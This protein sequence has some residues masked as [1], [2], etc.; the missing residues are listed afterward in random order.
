NYKI[1]SYLVKKKSFLAKKGGKLYG[2]TLHNAIYHKHSRIALFLIN[3][4]TPLNERDVQG[5]TPLHLATQRGN[6]RLV[7]T[8]V[9]NGASI[10]IINHN[11]KIP[12]QLIPKLIWDDEKEMERVLYPKKKTHSNVKKSHSF[13]DTPLS[14]SSDDLSLKQ[15]KYKVHTTIDKKSKLKNADIGINIK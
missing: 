15:N 9:Q 6:L 3:Q 4:G 10:H 8:L 14:Y 1:V 11:R 5:N 7:R 13:K 2:T 12:Y